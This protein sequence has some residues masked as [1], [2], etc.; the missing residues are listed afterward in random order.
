MHTLRTRAR[1]LLS[2]VALGLAVGILLTPIGIAHVGLDADD[3]LLVFQGTGSD[4][5]RVSSI[6]ASGLHHHC[7]TCE[8]L[9]SLRHSLVATG[10]IS[11]Q[12]AKTGIVRTSA[13]EVLPWVNRHALPARAPP[14]LTTPLLS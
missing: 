10:G 7:F 12:S 13:A 1:R 2:T 3:C 14:A 11:I 6:Q 5:S 9:Q 4:V 8:W